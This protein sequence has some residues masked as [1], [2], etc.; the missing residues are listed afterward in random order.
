MYKLFQEENPEVNVS[1]LTYCQ[2][3]HNEFSLRFGLSA[4]IRVQ[5]V[6][7]SYTIEKQIKLTKFT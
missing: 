1:N 4:L 3:F 5:N 2:I 7:T 6:T